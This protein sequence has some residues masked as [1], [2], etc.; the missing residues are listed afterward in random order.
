MQFDASIT[1]FLLKGLL[2][3]TWCETLLVQSGAKTKKKELHNSGGSGA[4]H[5][6]AKQILIWSLSQK[7]LSQKHLG[8]LRHCL[9]GLLLWSA[10][11][12]VFFQTCFI[13]LSN[14]TIWVQFQLLP[15]QCHL[16]SCRQSRRQQFWWWYLSSTRQNTAW[17]LLSHGNNSTAFNRVALSAPSLICWPWWVC[18]LLVL[19]LRMEQWWPLSVLSSV[20]VDL[21]NV[22][23]FWHG[24][25]CCLQR[26]YR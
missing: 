15:L 20:M 2:R 14:L 5:S 4:K 9:D 13:L 17:F 10:W 22:P 7:A 21:W 16:W 18:L 26:N 8:M 6:R 12:T 23:K 11:K 3:S 1:L 25:T 24:K 19:L